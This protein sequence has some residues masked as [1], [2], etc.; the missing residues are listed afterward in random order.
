M[1]FFLS[2]VKK[3]FYFLQVGFKVVVS[4]FG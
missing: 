1:F 4:F 3:K 2:F